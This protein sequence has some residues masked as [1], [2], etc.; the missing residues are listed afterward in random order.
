MDFL[1]PF[2]FRVSLGRGSNDKK[3]CRKGSLRNLKIIRYCLKLPD[4]IFSSR[5]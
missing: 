2:E 5:S 1:T 3:M 4:Q